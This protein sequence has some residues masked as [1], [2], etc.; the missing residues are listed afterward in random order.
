MPQ[1]RELK[2]FPSTLKPYNST[3]IVAN[4]WV[5][6]FSPNISWGNLTRSA[7]MTPQPYSTTTRSTTSR[8]YMPKKPR[9]KTHREHRCSFSATISSILSRGNT[10]YRATSSMNGNSMTH[11]G[12]VKM[13][14][15]ITFS[16]RKSSVPHFQK[17]TRRRR[18]AKAPSCPRQISGVL[19]GRL[20]VSSNFL[21]NSILFAKNT[22]VRKVDRSEGRSLSRNWNRYIWDAVN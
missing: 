22:W 4:R 6:L 17:H 10:R 1:P 2:D 19:R 20:A 16:S 3:T 12:T 14:N 7:A 8:G 21:I 18:A 11:L 5:S 9:I 13:C 15:N